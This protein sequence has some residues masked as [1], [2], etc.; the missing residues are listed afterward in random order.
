MA[1]QTSIYFVNTELFERARAYAEINGMSLSAFIE[2]CV[3]NEMN[4]F[5]SPSKEGDLNVECKNGKM[6]R[7]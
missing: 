3:L 5:G 4:R 1:H 7:M 6:G 2:S